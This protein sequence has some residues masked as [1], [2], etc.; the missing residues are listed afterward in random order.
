M[1]SKN[2][3]KL[4]QSLNRKKER[5]ELGLFVAEGD[6]C[7]S[8]LINCKLSPILIAT[9]NSN[10]SF[11]T[12]D[13]TEIEITEQA[14]IEKASLLKT[15][16]DSIAVFRQKKNPQLNCNYQKDLIL[17]LDSVQ[18]PGNFGTIIRL[19]NW[20]GIKSIICSVTTVDCYNPKVVQAS[21][22]AIGNVNIN[23]I[24][25]AEYLK[26]AKLDGASIYG[27]FL[28]GE[29]IYSKQLSPSGIIVMGNEGNGICPQIENLIN[30]RLYIPSFATGHVESLNVSIATAITLSEFRR[31]NMHP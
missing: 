1:L 10:H 5:D 7:I 8:E 30:D 3:I 21:M 23:Y 14:L 13:S 17:A 2:R 12:S 28:E 26:N 20:F 18:D 29:N 22:G 24:D 31:R 9:S 6:K 11:S 4:I 27:T 19:A 16:Q 25:L 15:P